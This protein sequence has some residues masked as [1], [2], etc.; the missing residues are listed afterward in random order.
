[1]SQRKKDKTALL[2]GRAFAI[3]ADL[4]DERQAGHAPNP[5]DGQG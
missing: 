4:V 1:M 2:N 5:S 3:P